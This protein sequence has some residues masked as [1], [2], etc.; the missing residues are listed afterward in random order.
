MDGSFV[1]A[2]LAGARLTGLES[3]ELLGIRFKIDPFELIR[4][5]LVCCQA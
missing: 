4:S 3:V 2:V 5:K 1:G